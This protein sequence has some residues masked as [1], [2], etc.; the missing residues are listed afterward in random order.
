M[1]AEPRIVSPRHLDHRHYHMLSRRRGNTSNRWRRYELATQQLRGKPLFRY[2][3]LTHCNFLYW[4][5]RCADLY[6]FR[7][8]NTRDESKREETPEPEGD[9]PVGRGTPKFRSRRHPPR[10]T[11]ITFGLTRK[12]WHLKGSEIGIFGKG[13]QNRMHLAS[14]MSVASGT[15]VSASLCVLS[16]VWLWNPR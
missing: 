15:S 12:Q 4:F 14:K 9:S 1:E 7:S 6:A 16:S 8:A 5:E 2:V 10:H 13:K 3:T 11:V